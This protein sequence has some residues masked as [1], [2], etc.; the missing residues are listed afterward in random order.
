[1]IDRYWHTIGTRNDVYIG[2]PM[3]NAEELT[4]EQYR[5]LSRPSKSLKWQ[6]FKEDMQDMADAKKREQLYT[7][8][9]YKLVGDT[10]D[11]DLDESRPFFNTRTVDEMSQM[12]IKYVGDND[13]L[14]MLCLAGKAEAK[15]YIRSLFQGE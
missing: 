7:F 6:W 1:M 9:R 15:A 4:E 8:L 14:A 3:A 2:V 10:I 12:Y 13:E 11:G 5:A